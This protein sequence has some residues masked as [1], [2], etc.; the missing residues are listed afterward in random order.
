MSVCPWSTAF[1][2]RLKLRLSLQLA[3]S[4]SDERESILG[5]G[6]LLRRGE[7][8]CV[9]AVGKTFP[10]RTSYPKNT[11][12]PFLFSQNAATMGSRRVLWMVCRWEGVR[13]CLHFRMPAFPYAQGIYQCNLN[14]TFQ[15]VEVFWSGCLKHGFISSLYFQS[16][17]VCCKSLGL[18]IIYINQTK[19]MG[20][21]NV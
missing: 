15:G 2:A 17:I 3:L 20:V 4:T 7:I 10:K 5:Q 12:R 8:F 18:L 14:L 19:S 1:C 9:G 6:K 21:S 11:L 13:Q 16:S